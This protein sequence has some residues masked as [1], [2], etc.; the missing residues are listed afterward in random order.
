MPQESMAGS[1]GSKIDHAAQV[2]GAY[3]LPP[4]SHSDRTVSIGLLMY[5]EEGK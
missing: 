1:E 3:C 5:M 4:V 2:G